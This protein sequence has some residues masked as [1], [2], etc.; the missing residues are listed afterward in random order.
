MCRSGLRIWVVIP[1]EREP[2]QQQFELHISF[3]IT[4]TNCHFR[5][6]VVIFQTKYLLLKINIHS[7]RRQSRQGVCGKSLIKERKIRKIDCVLMFL[8]WSLLGGF[9]VALLLTCRHSS[10]PPLCF[11][12]S[13]NSWSVWSGS[14]ADHLCVVTHYEVIVDICH[15]FWLLQTKLIFFLN[16]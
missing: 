9:S 7:R 16:Q 3:S 12:N 14:A 2:L 6:Y 15:C 1:L 4:L 5:F 13:L 10:H 11:I 8:K